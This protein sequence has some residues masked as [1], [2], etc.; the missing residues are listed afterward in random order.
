MPGAARVSTT[1]ASVRR[2]NPTGAR[3][4]EVKRMGAGGAAGNKHS[5]ARARLRSSSLIAPGWRLASAVRRPRGR[6]RG[7]KK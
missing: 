2:C 5:H 1:R 6:A 4:E 7:E 3:G